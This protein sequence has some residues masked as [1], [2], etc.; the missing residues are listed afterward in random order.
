MAF[1]LS[2][3][4]F[5]GV[6]LRV[7]WWQADSFMTLL[8]DGVIHS[9]LGIWP[10][11]LTEKQQL[12]PCSSRWDGQPVVF[13]PGNKVGFLGHCGRTTTF[14]HELGV[15]RRVI[16]NRH[17]QFGKRWQ[18]LRHQPPEEQLT[19]YLSMVVAAGVFGCV[20]QKGALSEGISGASR[21]HHEAFPFHGR[22]L[23]AVGRA[24]AIL[25]GVHPLLAVV[26]P[27]GEPR[28]VQVDHLPSFLLVP[29]QSL[30]SSH[31]VAHNV[32]GLLSYIHL[33]L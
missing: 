23:T 26:H 11:L 8:A 10:V 14:I 32:Q 30:E 31:P 18:D 24:A 27:G 17:R 3:H 25:R 6:Q 15:V 22:H 5:D 2:P 12:K 28:F 7:G 20:T 13:H 21:Y 19:V 29:L 4:L 9:V 1:Y 16:K 33:S